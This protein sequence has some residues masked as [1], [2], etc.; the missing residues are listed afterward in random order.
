MTSW[1][2][3]PADAADTITIELLLYDK[4]RMSLQQCDVTALVA[5]NGSII[6]GA[7]VRHIDLK[8]TLGTVVSMVDDQ[9]LILWTRAPELFGNGVPS[10]RPKV[11]TGFMYH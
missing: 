9:A 11:L 2:Y 8:E 3:A 7:L 1:Y 5:I 6:P 4:Y 10:Y